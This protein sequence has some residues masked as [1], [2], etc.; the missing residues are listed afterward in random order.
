MSKLLVHVAFPVNNLPVELLTR[1]FILCTM[2]DPIS[3]GIESINGHKCFKPG[4]LNLAYVCRFWQKA[5]INHPVL[6]GSQVTNEF[7]PRWMRTMLER[8]KDAA[9]LLHINLVHMMYDNQ[10]SKLGNQNGEL[11]HQDCELSDEYSELS[12]K[13][14][15]LSNEDAELSN[16]DAGLKEKGTDL[17]A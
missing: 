15:E 7:G 11:D 4:W 14:A 9:V 6:W 2:A 16:E 8:S 17:I 5:A 3:W 12:D 13:D 10:G 1:L